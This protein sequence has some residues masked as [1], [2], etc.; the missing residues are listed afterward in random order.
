MESLQGGPNPVGKKVPLKGVAFGEVGKKLVGMRKP[1]GARE[2][3]PAA[4]QR[5]TVWY[6]TFLYFD[7]KIT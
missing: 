6:R 3:N 7:T 5:L 4:S 1:G 2:C